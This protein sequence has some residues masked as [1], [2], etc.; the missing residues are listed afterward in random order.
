MH[1]TERFNVNLFSKWRNRWFELSKNSQP[2]YNR[3]VEY[4]NSFITIRRKKQNNNYFVR[5]IKYKRIDPTGL[6]QYVSHNT[7]NS[8]N[9]KEAL[10]LRK[11]M[12]DSGQ[13]F[14]Q[15]VVSTV[16]IGK[17]ISKLC[18]LLPS[19]HTRTCYKTLSTLDGR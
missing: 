1:K 8:T 16:L 15:H 11:Q 3:I 19:K 7:S 10:A 6:F 5:L 13:M 14:Y 2:I 18:L 12:F 17:L 4:G 9:E